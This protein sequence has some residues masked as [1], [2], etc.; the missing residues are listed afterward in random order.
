MPAKKE[1]FDEDQDEESEKAEEKKGF[2]I[3]ISTIIAGI[4]FI[5]IAEAFFYLLSTKTEASFSI[6]EIIFGLIVAIT[7]TLFLMW[8]KF[9]MRSNKY[10][11]ATIGIMGTGIVIYAL[12]TQFTGAY[13]NI[14]TIISAVVALGYIGMHFW[15]SGNK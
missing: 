8:V 10:L 12:R 4:I 5:I 6:K 11:G 1:E 2:S 14:F 15:K 13:T 7:I 3:G 9:I